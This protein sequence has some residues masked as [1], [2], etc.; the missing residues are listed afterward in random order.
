[1]TNDAPLDLA[2]IDELEQKA[3]AG[4]WQHQPYGGQNQNG[5]YSGGAVFDADGEYLVSDVSDEAGA[6]IA[7][8]RTDLPALV[9]E[10]RSQAE[11]ISTAERI[12]LGGI[13]QSWS[14]VVDQALLALRG[15]NQ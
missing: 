8:A 1:M 13:G 10:V 15:T 9:A 12:L 2:R 7:A 11:R 5:D 14:R 3:P 6:F 4:P